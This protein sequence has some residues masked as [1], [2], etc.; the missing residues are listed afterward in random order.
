MTSFFTRRKGKDPSQADGSTRT[1]VQNNPSKLSRSLKRK[2]KNA[3]EPEPEFNLELALP[4]RND[5]RTSLI[6][7]G[8]SARFSMLREQNDPNTKIGK[9]NDDSVL[10]PSRASRLNLF[11]HNPLTDI[12]EVESI[13][14]VKPPFAND[15][16]NS[17][18]E[19]YASDDT[20]SIMNRIK[21]SEG[22]NLF[23]GR[24]KLYK[25]PNGAS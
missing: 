2:Q 16:S 1:E 24:Q 9:A 6:L 21:A 20:G 11:K 14:T 17:I 5:F 7:P 4:D 18:S 22:N 19:G 15:G 12:S 8:L 10:F 13:Y 23:S 3:P 25:V